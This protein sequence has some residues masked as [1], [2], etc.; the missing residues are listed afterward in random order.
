MRQ[1]D[2]MRQLYMPAIYKDAQHPLRNL[3]KHGMETY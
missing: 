1:L 2:M 3:F